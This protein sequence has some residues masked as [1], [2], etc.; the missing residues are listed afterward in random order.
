MMIH[1]HIMQ[2]PLS[3][4]PATVGGVGAT[5]T[6]SATTVGGVGATVT[7][8]ATTVGNSL[9]YSFATPK[10]V[11]SSSGYQVYHDSLTHTS[12]WCLPSHPGSSEGYLFPFPI[13]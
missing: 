11:T 13:Q 1:V 5:V 7:T 2:L 3:Q 6:T 9:N 4:T 8:S 12:P 10:P